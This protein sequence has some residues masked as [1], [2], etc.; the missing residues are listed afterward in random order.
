MKKPKEHH[1]LE[2]GKFYQLYDRDGESYKIVTNSK[3]DLEFWKRVPGLCVSSIRLC[4]AY[5]YREI[6]EHSFNRIKRAVMNK[7]GL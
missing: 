5:L 7:L 2:E 1:E 6:T 3:I 4:D